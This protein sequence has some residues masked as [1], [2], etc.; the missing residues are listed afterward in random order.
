MSIGVRVQRV[1]DYPDGVVSE[2]IAEELTCVAR[3]QPRA[4]LGQEC[5]RE[6]KGQCRVPESGRSLE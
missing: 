5:P 3:S 2:G 6:G 4:D 1:G